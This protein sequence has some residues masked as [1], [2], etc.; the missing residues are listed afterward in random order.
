MIE[1]GADEAPE[2]TILRAFDFSRGGTQV[3][4][5]STMC[6]VEHFGSPPPASAG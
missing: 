6:L 5:L 2:E 3:I 1:A 4:T